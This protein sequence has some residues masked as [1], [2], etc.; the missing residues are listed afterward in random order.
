MLCE[1]EGAKGVMR[2]RAHVMIGAVEQAL[3]G[4]H[5]RC[6]HSSHLTHQ[7]P[8]RQQM[9]VD[10]PP[11][12]WRCAGGG[13]PG[14]GGGADAGGAGAGGRPQG[15]H[16]SR[17]P[18]APGRHRARAGGASAG[19]SGSGSRVAL[20]PRTLGNDLLFCGHCRV[21]HAALSA[22]NM[23]GVEC[24]HIQPSRSSAC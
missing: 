2:A 8:H 15:A 21:R 3:L 16:D 5:T 9:V 13:H 20:L 4:S 1:L 19:G 23:A 18:A 12:L 11:P 14:A 6:L 22:G 7:K 24:C 10:V 17:R